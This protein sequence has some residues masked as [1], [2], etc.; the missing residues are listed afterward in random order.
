MRH[1]QKEQSKIT[2]I[3]ILREKK[4]YVK[5]VLTRVTMGVWLNVDKAPNA[6]LLER[7]AMKMKIIIDIRLDDSANHWL[8]ITLTES[9]LKVVD[10]CLH[11][12]IAKSLAAPYNSMSKFFSSSSTI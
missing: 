1:P 6:L 5:R 10:G 3:D 9:R 12:S 8:S 2:K 7:K 4:R 11:S